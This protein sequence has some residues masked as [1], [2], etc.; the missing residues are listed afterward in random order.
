M[1]NLSIIIMS[2]VLVGLGGGAI[3]VLL[4]TKR[5]EKRF[6]TALENSQKEKDHQT[7]RLNIQPHYQ[8]VGRW[9]RGRS[10]GPTFSGS[11]SQRNLSATTRC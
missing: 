3:F 11:H 7:S 9:I 4:R 2:L 6:K 1:L 5:V 10:L 8:V